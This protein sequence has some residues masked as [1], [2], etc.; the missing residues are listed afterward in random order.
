M[1]AIFQQA[2]SAAFNQ[3]P[4]KS[5]ENF[6]KVKYWVAFFIGAKDSAEAAEKDLATLF[7]LETI[8]KGI[9]KIINDDS[10]LPSF[11]LF[12]VRCNTLFCVKGFHRPTEL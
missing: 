9:E 1:V 6:S 4:P 5:L 3:N 8:R 7:G 10:R 12:T 11:L 2:V